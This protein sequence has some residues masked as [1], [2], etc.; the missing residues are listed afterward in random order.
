MRFSFLLLA[1]LFLGF[2][3]DNPQD[4]PVTSTDFH[5]VY[6]NLPLVAEAA[7]THSM[8]PEM[9]KF[10]LKR[11]TPIDHKAALVNALGWSQT[12]TPNFDAFAAAV[13]KKRKIHTLSPDSR[14]KAHDQL[15]LGYLLLLEDYSHP[16]K[17][18]PYLE[19]A[20]ARLPDSRTAQTL[21]AI[22][23][24]QISF[25]D[26]WCEVWQH[27]QKVKENTSLTNDL[28]AEADQIIYEYL[29]LYQDS[30]N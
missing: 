4:S 27:Y 24:A 19:K 14:M 11:R 18:S 8:T 23:R 6:L 1:F 26:S 5:R 29:V 7:R 21:L 9:E 3:S 15:M 12:N 20:A 30:C 10:L 22:C 28:K 2:T 16:E 13:K 25:D 17:A